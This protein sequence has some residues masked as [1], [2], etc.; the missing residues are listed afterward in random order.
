MQ[1]TSEARL[2]EVLMRSCAIHGSYLAVHGTE[3][4]M[5]Y[6]ELATTAQLVRSELTASGH[7]PGEPV[8][9]AVSNAVVDPAY[10]LGVWLARGVSIPISHNSS[11]STFSELIKRSGARFL[12]SG[13]ELIPEVWRQHLVP[14]ATVVKAIAGPFERVPDELDENQALVIFTSG[15]TGTPKGVVLSHRAFTGKLAAIQSRLNFRPIEVTLQ[16]LHLQFSFGQWTTLLTLCTGGTIKMI[17]RF[18]ALNT[19]SQL[20]DQI[21]R[22]PVV[23]T[24]L[25]MILREASCSTGR[26]TVEV[27]RARQSPRLW[28]AGGEPLDAGL[29]QQIRVLFPNS[30]IADVF[31][32]SES[33]TSDFIVT[34]DRYDHLAGTLGDEPTPGVE[35]KVTTADGA[36][37]SPGDVGELRLRTP[38]L[39]TG[40][41]G[42]PQ[43]T[44]DT[45]SGA[46]LKTGDLAM[47][48]EEGYV[49]LVGRSKNLIVRGG[50][51]IA[52]L[53]LEAVYSGYPGCYGAMA[54]GIPDEVLGERIH[55]LLAVA[56]G[57]PSLKDLRSW[58]SNWLDRFKLP[59]AV[60]LINELPMGRTGKIDRTVGRNLV[61][62]MLAA[63][64]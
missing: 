39:M 20:S 57:R 17:K 64:E 4:A 16:P 23:P 35:A 59:D 40:Y 53:E 32:L 13:E 2:D 63:T 52:P 6:H 22:I 44:A 30:G 1:L 19:I 5:T 9:V 15:S 47:I 10:Q 11:I 27:A 8:L 43:A 18:T 25:R 49:K 60:H 46:W 36:R 7:T 26:R 45:L 58:G 51:K 33:C 14:A 55:L 24:M 28:I 50:T 62:E 48:T 37:C 54:V 56:D 38:F 3:G 21:D 31:G 42:D 61:A 41:L 12:I 34:A 29:G